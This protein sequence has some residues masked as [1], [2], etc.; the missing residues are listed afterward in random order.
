MRG[1]VRGKVRGNNDVALMEAVLTIKKA[2]SP[3]PRVHLRMVDKDRPVRFDD[4]PNPPRA[5]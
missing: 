3:A 4:D 2:N 1:K 5:A